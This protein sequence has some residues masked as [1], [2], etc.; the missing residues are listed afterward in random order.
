MQR[1][2]GCMRGTGPRATGAGARFFCS[3]GACPPHFFSLKQDGQDGQD[4]QDEG[5][6][7]SIQ[8]CTGH[9]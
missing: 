2:L 8:I 4:L 7:R 9:D 1:R 5:F 3:A 6:L